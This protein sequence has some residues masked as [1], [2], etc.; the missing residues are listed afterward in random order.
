MFRFR[1]LSM[2][3][4]ILIILLTFATYFDGSVIGSEVTIKGTVIE[5]FCLLTMGVKGEGHRE[6]A[7]RC[8]KAGMNLAIMDEKGEIFPILPGEAFKNPN[9]LV[10]GYVEK[11]VTVGGNLIESGG[12]RYIVIKEV[13]SN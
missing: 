8:A 5:P 3:L 12:V 6:C 2:S 10:F 9:N 11:T 7:Q 4:W 13:K 1:K